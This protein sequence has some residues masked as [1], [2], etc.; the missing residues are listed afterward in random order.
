MT[1]SFFRLAEDGREFFG[2]QSAVGE[3][4][5]GHGTKRLKPLNFSLQFGG[6]RFRHI[7]SLVTNLLNRFNDLLF[8]V[9]FRQVAESA[10]T[11]RGL[12]DFH[13]T[14][15]RKHKHIGMG[16]RVA[17]DSRDFESVKLRQAQIE[18]HQVGLRAFRQLD[19][20]RTAR[21][22]AADF[23]FGHLVQGSLQAV[24]GHEMVVDHEHAIR[25]PAIFLAT[26]DFLAAAFFFA[27]A[28]FFA[29]ADFLAATSFAL[30]LGSALGVAGVAS[31]AARVAGVA[32]GVATVAAR[33]A[34]DFLSVSVHAAVRVAV[35]IC[36]PAV[37]AADSV[38]GDTA[39][40][41]A[42]ASFFAWIERT[43]AC[44]RCLFPAHDYLPS[45]E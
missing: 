19:R 3:L 21:R 17:N 37:A 40:H 8:A 31:V 32:A 14:V 34:I 27:N 9:R 10:G 44:L 39:V 7:G 35:D 42:S 16:Q 28:F 18:D 41:V 25:F 26:A 15:M 24:T 30:F 23:D 5:L 2:V 29:T 36:A 38:A 33:V 13:R 6:K 20:V 4:R 43:A 45:N 11:Q 12:G 1:N 22:F